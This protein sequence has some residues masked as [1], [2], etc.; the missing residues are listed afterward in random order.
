MSRRWKSASHCRNAL[1]ILKDRI[2]QHPSGV[3][4]PPPTDTQ[5]PD[6]TEFLSGKETA[7]TTSGLSRSKRRRT[8]S[9]ARVSGGNSESRAFQEDFITASEAEKSTERTTAPEFGS[10]EPPFH[11]HQYNFSTDMFQS[12]D[13][14]SLLQLVDQDPLLPG[15]PGNFE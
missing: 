8:T 3:S 4:P 9:Q 6:L 11:A 10:I 14:E 13:W 7:S 5:S 15:F 1:R 2:D 12:T